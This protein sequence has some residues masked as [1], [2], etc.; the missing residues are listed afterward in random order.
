MEDFPETLSAGLRSQDSQI[1]API[2]DRASSMDCLG[3]TNVVTKLQCPA[4]HGRSSVAGT[5]QGQGS[6]AAGL[7]PTPELLGTG[8]LEKGTQFV[9][10]AINSSS[11]SSSPPVALLP[12]L[13]LLLLL[14]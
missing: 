9:E 7:G 2:F 12:P 14:C 8:L 13:L 11:S 10:S 5:A 6:R 4:L 1:L 3:S